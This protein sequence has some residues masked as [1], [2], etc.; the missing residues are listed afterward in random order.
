MLQDKCVCVSVINCELDVAN[1]MCLYITSVQTTHMLLC[2]FM[3]S[4]H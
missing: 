2:G 4:F 1:M 3:I